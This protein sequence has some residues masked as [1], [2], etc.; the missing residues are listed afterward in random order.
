MYKTLKYNDIDQGNIDGSH[1]LI[2][3]RSPKEYNAE[4]IPDA[5]NIPIFGDNERELIGT[6]Y[7][8]KSIEEAKKMGIKA[9]AEK[10]PQIYDHIATLDKEYNNLIFFCAR[11]G[12]RSSSLVSL[13]KTLGIHAYKLDGGYKKYRKYINRTLP[14]VMEGMQFVVLYGNTGTG[15]T[16]ILEVMQEMGH[17]II[18]LEGCANHRG[19]LLGGVGLG[20]PNT[21]KMFESMLYESLK[22]RKTNTVY[23][24]GESKKIGR[25]VIPGFIYDSMNNGIALKIEAGIEARIDNILRDYVHETDKELINSLDQLRRY[26]GNK[27]I[28]RYMDM[29][30]R[31]EYRG[32]AK[33]LMIKYYDPLYEHKNRTFI[34]TFYNE[35]NVKTARQII[36]WVETRLNRSKPI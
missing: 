10:L 9:A 4:T 25:V 22:T 15:K 27:N 13:F 1:I 20:K 8:Q 11:G 34:K 31:S 26:I 17:D 14:K 30:R 5:I 18:D 21:Q 24:E 3:V 35:D 7:N 12:F 19:S 2:D 23:I 16:H 33:E 36:E 28:D 29:I 6:I 32:V